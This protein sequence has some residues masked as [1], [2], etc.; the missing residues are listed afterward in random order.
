DRASEPAR[1]GAIELL[2]GIDPN[3]S[4]ALLRDVLEPRQP[5]TVQVAAVRALAEGRAANLPDLL[6]PRLR[7]FEPAVRAAAVRTL[8]SRTEWTKALLRAAAK[9]GT[10]S[11]ISPAL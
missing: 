4:R 10:Q 3:A 2:S 1:V 7:G 11:G 9:S 5:V 6:L 8:L